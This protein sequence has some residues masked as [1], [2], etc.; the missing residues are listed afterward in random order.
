[1]SFYFQ[2]TNKAADYKISHNLGQTPTE[3]E[4][5]W[6]AGATCNGAAD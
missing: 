3:T 6:I 5:K 1:L 4:E 2:N